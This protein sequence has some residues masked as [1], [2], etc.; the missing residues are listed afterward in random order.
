MRKKSPKRE[1][2]LMTLL[3]NEATKESRSLLKK[4]K[5]PDAKGYNDLELK[6][7][8]LYTSMPDKF[9]LEKEMAEIHPHKNWL[10]R[11]LEL[12]KPKEIKAEKVEVETIKQMPTT[13]SNVCLNPYCPI[14][15]S[16]PMCEYSNASGAKNPFTS[17][18][19]PNTQQS[20]ETQSVRNVSDYA[21]LVA[22]I[23][24]IGITFYVIT[25]DK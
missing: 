16:I 14:H 5:R 20:S 6:L 25:K 22:V 19:K 13:P 8:E 17:E 9:A 21:G 11:R 2:T 1:L 10:L 18:G 7:A 4:Y 3:A 23:A 24:M 15:G 12:D